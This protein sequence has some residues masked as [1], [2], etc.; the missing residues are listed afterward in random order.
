MRRIDQGFEDEASAKEYMQELIE[1]GYVNVESVPGSAASQCTCDHTPG[2]TTTKCCNLCGLPIAGEC[3]HIPELTAKDEEI[4][5][6]REA[7]IT[8]EPDAEFAER[9][10]LKEEIAKLR[11]ALEMIAGKRPCP[12]NTMSDKQIALAALQENTE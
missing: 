5:K 12:D 9:I 10:M 4:A 2:W 11:E 8:A 3:W 1:L 7:L 6:L